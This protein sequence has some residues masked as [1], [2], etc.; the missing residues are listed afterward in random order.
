MK[1]TLVVCCMLLFVSISLF[2]DTI[3]LKSGKTIEGKILERAYDCI[4]VDIG[5]TTLTYYLDD[6]AT[7]NSET[8]VYDPQANLS[9]H[10]STP[11]IVESQSASTEPARSR[12]SGVL[13]SIPQP[14]GN[15]TSGASRQSQENRQQR[16][17]YSP[18]GQT[19]TQALF[20]QNNP[21]YSL[22]STLGIADT[23]M[24]ATLGAV[25]LIFVIFCVFFYVYGA[26]C[27]YLISKKTGK[28]TA[29]LAWVPI[30]NLFLMCKIADL[31]YVWLFALLLMFI[32]FIGGL[33]VSV[34]FVFVWYRMAVARG[35]PGWLGIL[36]IVPLA[37]LVV[38]GYLA[39]SE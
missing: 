34:G 7:I 31:S 36:T 1:K 3:V 11:P 10:P 4:K 22:F 27:L 17:T 20:T 39:F 38:M 37:N 6:I 21:L 12:V 8:V 9:Q 13:G 15:D 18:P 5:G 26:I 35:K 2:A 23:A 19:D 14:I 33:L 29:L 28:G 24:M 16:K 32:P 25:M 30:A